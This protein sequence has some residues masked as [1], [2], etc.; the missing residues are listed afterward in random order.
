MI[1]SF[2]GQVFTVSDYRI[3]TPNGLQGSTGSD[4]A[5]H[6][7]IGKKARS[8]WMGPKLKKYSMELL[9]RAQDGVNPRQTLSS[10]QQIAESDRTDWFIVGGTPLSTYPFRLL[11]VSDSWGA[12]IR[13]GV[14]IECK[15]S[16]TIEEYI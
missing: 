6:E 14:L 16:L 8:Q 9:L 13:G 15:V 4:W 1:G 3:Y 2:M 7:I 10:L 11:E 12:V 5:T